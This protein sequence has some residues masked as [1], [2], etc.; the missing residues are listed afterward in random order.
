[1][2]KPDLVSSKVARVLEWLDHA[3]RLISVSPSLL[4]DMERRDLASFYIFLGAQ[5]S[6]SLAARWV[7]DAGWGSPEDAAS[8]F[9]VLADHKA[10]DRDL[11]ESLRGAVGLRNRIADGYAPVD[12][13]KIQS[14]FREAAEA[15]RRFLALV[16]SEAGL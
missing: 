2:A 10:I 4:A 12:P 14:Q 5:K 1:M 13:A 15:M 11:A 8:I 7:A 16:S 6:I 3:E 9:D